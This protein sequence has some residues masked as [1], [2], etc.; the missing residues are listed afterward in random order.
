M[1]IESNDSLF[2]EIWKA[3]VVYMYRVALILMC[4]VDSLI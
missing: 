2:K 1:Y 3:K 4:T